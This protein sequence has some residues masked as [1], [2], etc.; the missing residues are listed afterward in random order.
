MPPDLPGPPARLAQREGLLRAL[1]ER[2][3]RLTW[4]DLH[5]DGPIEFVCECSRPG[6]WQSVE[7]TRDEYEAIRGRPGHFLL[8]PGHEVEGV[9]RVVEQHERYVVVEPG[10]IAVGPGA[11]DELSWRSGPTG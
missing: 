3:S 7:L 5:F 6:C 8:L 10:G 1:N 11:S 4:E 2:I 9:D